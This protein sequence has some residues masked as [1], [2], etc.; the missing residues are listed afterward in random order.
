MSRL[1]SATIWLP[2]RKVHEFAELVGFR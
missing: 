2:R 1:V